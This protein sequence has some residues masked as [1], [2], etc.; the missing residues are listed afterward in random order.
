MP[1][2]KV[3]EFNLGDVEDPDLYVAAPIMEWQNT[4]VGQ[5]V[6][7]HS[8]DTVFQRHNNPLVWGY[9]YSIVADL[10][11]QDAVFFTLKWQ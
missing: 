1:Q 3:H 11:D 10:S 7:Q 2:V 6:M 8:S 5:W 4:E 9:T